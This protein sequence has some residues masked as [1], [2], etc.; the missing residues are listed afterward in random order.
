MA[1]S[2]FSQA[3]GS[4]EDLVRIHGNP[5]TLYAKCGGV[6]G[7]SAFVDRCMERWMAD[8]ALNAN[9]A[10]TTWHLKAQRCGFKFLV[11]QIVCN[12]TG[13][14]Q[15]Y[16]GRPLDQA[17]KHLNISEE[18][19]GTFMDIF[20]D[21]CGEFGLARD[22][23]DDLNALMISMEMDCVVYPGETVPANPGP[24]RPSGQSLYARVGG[25][26]PLALFVDRLVDALLAD[27]RVH[28]PLD[29]QKRNETSMKYLFTELV[30]SISGGPETVTAKGH[31]ETMLLLP[32]NEWRILMATAEVAADHLPAATRSSLM[33]VLESSKKHIV[34]PSSGPASRIPA[35]GT[36]QAAAVKDV[37]AAAAGKMLSK[38]A[39]AARHAA[40]GAMVAARKRVLGDPRTLYGRGGGIFGLARLSDRMMEV[41]MANPTLNGN[42]KVARWHESQQ[43]YGFK[44]LVTQIMGYL[45]GGPQRY[46]GRPMD[47]AHKHLGITG[48]EWSLFMADAGKVFHELGLDKDTQQ[49]LSGI[50]STYQSSCVVAPGEAAPADPGRAKPAGDRN[51]LYYR[52]GGVYPIAQFVDRLVEKVLGDT[53]IHV[54]YDK[55]VD[56]RGKRHPPGLKYMLTEL[57][58]N[59]TGGP[60]VVTSK[61]FDEAKLGIQVEEWPVFLQLAAEAAEV[62]PLPHLRNAV[63]GALGSIKAEICLGIIEEDNTPEAKARRMLLDAG[64]DHYFSTSALEKCAGDPARALELLAQGWTPEALSV[65]SG[66]TGA[67]AGFD[68]DAPRCPFARPGATLP[69]GHPPIQGL[70]TSAGPDKSESDGG[71]IGYLRSWTAYL[72]CTAQPVVNSHTETFVEPQS[73]PVDDKLEVAIRALAEK[74]MSP[75][76]IAPLLG[77]DEASVAAVVARGAISQGR[78]LGNNLQKKLDELLEEDAELCCPVSLLLFIDPVI[79]SDGFMYE[80]ASIEGLLR[81]RMVSPL[82]REPLQKEYTPARQRQ[83]AASEFRRV[84]SADLLRFA[85]E[86]ASLQPQMAASALERASDY[87]KVLSPAQPL[88]P[89]GPLARQAAKLWRKLGQPVPVELARY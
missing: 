54:A 40:P 7:V 41:W 78:V 49:E 4:S 30:C 48:H 60:E 37:R 81:A 13:G 74:G 46:T 36:P 72:S 11:V 58:C 55:L 33:Q 28:I 61:G 71:L 19:W 84:R 44:F 52:L 27:D 8:P 31:V 68:P 26:Y 34:D 86:A 45:T 38:E 75:S 82:T 24:A 18:E 1:L 21:V 73:A 83:H 69:S 59:G 79:A 29:M 3:R 12:L 16:T 17:H 77:I 62:W 50:L 22:T 9:Q 70:V 23:V 2:R 15:R 66:S 35:F 89:E 39:I 53:R 14:P 6:F 51:T 76:A 47:E 20:N 5:G 56:P 43:K 32:E 85:E 65:P 10:V 64:F 57:V 88:S 42:T 80:K 67:F 87:L 25:V 63:I